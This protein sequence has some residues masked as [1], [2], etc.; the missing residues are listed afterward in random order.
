MTLRW[1]VSIDDPQP[2]ESEFRGY[3]ATPHEALAALRE[4][5][6]PAWI[7]VSDVAARLSMRVTEIERALDAD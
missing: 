7:A 3:G 6:A 1:A 4:Q 2:D 5:V